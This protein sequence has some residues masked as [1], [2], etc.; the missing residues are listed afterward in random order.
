M[1]ALVT[2]GGGFLGRRIVELLVEQGHDVS[3]LARGSYPEV[4][5]LGARGHAIDLA[6][7]D[8]L[9][10]VVDGVDTIFH[11]AAKAGV[12]G[13]RDDFFRT[14][15][16]GTRNLMD[17]AEAAGVARL[18]YTSTPSVVS[19]ESDIENG[20]QDLPYAQAYKAWYP[21]SK[22]E[23]ERMVLQGNSRHLATV[24]LR[25]HL[26]F[27]PRDPHLLPRF[28][29]AA[30]A[31]RLRI[32]GDGTN[33]VDFTYVDNAAWAHLDAAA[34]LNSHE[35]ACAGKPYFI[36]ND[37]PVPLW[38]WFNEVLTELGVPRV[39]RKLSHGF[40][41]RVFGLIETA[42]RVLPL[43]EPTVTA[44]LADAMATSHWFDQEPA[45]RDFGY[46]IR[47]SMADAVAP[48]VAYLRSLE[49]GPLV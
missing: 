32:I 44:F 26:I 22:A 7:R 46:T 41:K 30:R 47:V 49:E 39:E 4:E 42:H 5:A 15:V 2:G 38:G 16:D 1:K 10:A 23:A 33:K 40:A 19:Y 35:A 20:A 6:D 31:G 24:A 48:T 11:V 34:A 37:E 14:N 17:A 8:K 12:W 36:S 21:A 18:V 9:G 45:K 28:V 43:G 25:P 27:G 3:F 13:A 29:E